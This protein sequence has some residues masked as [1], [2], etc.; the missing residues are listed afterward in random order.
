MVEKQVEEEVL[1][2][3][4]EDY[5]GSGGAEGRGKEEMVDGCG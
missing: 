3:E 4:E 2:R 1:K 5:R